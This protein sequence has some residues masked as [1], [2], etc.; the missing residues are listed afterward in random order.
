MKWFKS[1]SDED[2]SPLIG[3][4]MSRFGLKGYYFYKRTLGLLAKHFSIE[5]PGCNR[6]NKQFF[7]LQYYPAIK[8][9]RTIL[10][11]LNFLQDRLEIFYFFNEV[12][13]M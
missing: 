3:E 5:D 12:L 9:P 1:F 8:D 7:F 11:I 6:F 4:L 10:K 2:E 13:I